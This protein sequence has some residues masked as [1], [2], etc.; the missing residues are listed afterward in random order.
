[1]PQYAVPEEEKP[2]RSTA[3]HTPRHTIRVPDPLWDKMLA[4]AAKKG[5]DVSAVTRAFYE[6]YVK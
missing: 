5:T 6:E 2:K 4:K 1:M 3:G